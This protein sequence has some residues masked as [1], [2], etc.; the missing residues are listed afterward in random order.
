M[1]EKLETALTNIEITYKELIEI[2]NDIMRPITKEVNALI[3]Y[4]SDN[5]ES[6]SI[7]QIRNLIL[8]LS[9]KSFKFGDVKEK[10]ALKAK[11]AETLKNEAYAKEFAGSD[12]SVEAKKTAATTN[13]SSQVVAE[14]LYTLISSLFK[15]KLD[16]IH[17]C[18]D[19]LKSVLMSRMAEQKLLSNF[20][21]E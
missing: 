19:A 3:D 9:L 2:A 16:E 17:R 14:A 8:D 12:G 10:A 5:I 6:L 20:A 1:T 15:T 13:I 18:V 21:G 4:T 7:E 11:C